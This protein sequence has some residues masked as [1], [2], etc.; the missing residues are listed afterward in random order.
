M[1][2]MTIKEKIDKR[3]ECNKEILNILNDIIDKNPDLRFGQVLAITEAIQ[4]KTVN[5]IGALGAH[6]IEPIDP[7]N[8]EPVDTLKRMKQAFMH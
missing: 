2:T 5:K 3:Q 8:E 1:R 4:Y 7:F 6:E